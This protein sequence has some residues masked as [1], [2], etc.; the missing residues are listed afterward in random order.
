[1]FNL[2][3]FWRTNQDS[4]VPSVTGVSQEEVPKSFFIFVSLI[5]FKYL[6]GTTICMKRFISN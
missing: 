5:Y 2:S 1:L 3:I 6:T 4:C